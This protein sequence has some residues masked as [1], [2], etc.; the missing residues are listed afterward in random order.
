MKLVHLMW[1]DS[2]SPTGGGWKS[3]EGRDAESEKPILCESIGWVVYE[4]NGAI[5]IAGHISHGKS[6]G[7]VNEV[8]GELTIP[9]V[10]IVKRRKVKI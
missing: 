2:C 10:A 3:A 5:T 6:D 1:I 4:D 8:N 7:S 9:K